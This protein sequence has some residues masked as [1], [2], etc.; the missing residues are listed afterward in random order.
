MFAPGVSFVLKEEVVSGGFRRVYFDAERNPQTNGMGTFS[1]TAPNT[2]VTET[3][4]LYTVSLTLSHTN[5]D[6]YVQ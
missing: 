3:I 6:T 2:P 4:T 5:R 1:F